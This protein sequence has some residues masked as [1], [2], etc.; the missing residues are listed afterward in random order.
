MSKGSKFRIGT[1]LA[2]SAAFLWAVNIV[3]TKYIIKAGENPINVVF[4][5][6]VISL[7]FW[8]GRFAMKK[9]EARKASKKDYLVL[10]LMGII[11]TL[12]VSIIQIYALK[13]SQAI[14]YSFLI[15]SVM[16]FTIAF[17]AIFLK[18]KI[19]VKKVVLTVLILAGSYLVATSG[20]I[21]SLSIGDGLTLLNAALIAFGNTILGKIAAKTMSSGLSASGSFL[22]GFVPI[23][24]ITFLTGSFALPH[25]LWLILLLSVFGILSTIVRFRAYQHC[26]ASFLSMIYSMTPVFITLMAFFLLGETLT[27]IQVIGGLLIIFGGIYAE[28]TRI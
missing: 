13:Y 16:I 4:W 10:L 25:A 23:V 15:R 1:I 17:A 19:T 26:T 9:E 8:L 7:P 6:A 5:V 24:A 20:K 3:I 27:T 22:F 12:L 11:G 14:N 18:E 28:R 2:L 21:I